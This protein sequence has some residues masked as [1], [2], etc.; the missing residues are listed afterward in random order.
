MAKDL[1]NMDPPITK[2]VLHPFAHGARLSCLYEKGN[3]HNGSGVI[4]PW[5]AMEEKKEDVKGF[6]YAF[7]YTPVIH[8]TDTLPYTRKLERKENPPGNVAF[9]MNH[10][11]DVYAK[12]PNEIRWTFDMSGIKVVEGQYV[13]TARQ[14]KKS[15]II[16]DQLDADTLNSTLENSILALEADK[17]I[18]APP[19]TADKIKVLTDA[20]NALKAQKTKL[21]AA[22][23]TVTNVTTRISDPANVSNNDAFALVA[24]K[25]NVSNIVKASNT[26]NSLITGKD[27][28]GKAVPTVGKTS[29]ATKDLVKN[30]EDS[31][32]K[33]LTD[34]DKEKDI[35]VINLKANKDVRGFF[36]SYIN[37]YDSKNA[38]DDTSGTGSVSASAV[39]NGKFNWGI[40][41]T[42]SHTFFKDAETEEGKNC[43]YIL[44]LSGSV[45]KVPPPPDIPKENENNKAKLEAANKTLIEKEKTFEEA[46]AKLV[47]A[48]ENKDPHLDVILNEQKKAKDDVDAAKLAVTNASSSAT[49]CPTTF[50]ASQTKVA[51]KETTYT[52]DN[53]TIVVADSGS[54]STGGA[55]NIQTTTRTDP[56]GKTYKTVRTVDLVTGV[57]TTTN[58][59]IPAGVG[60]AVP[61]DIPPMGESD[62]AK[63]SYDMKDISDQCMFVAQL[64]ARKHP[65]LKSISTPSTFIALTCDE[66]L[67][68]KFSTKAENNE[69]VPC[70]SEPLFFSVTCS[71]PFSG[72]NLSKIDRKYY[73][74]L[75]F[76]Y[77]VENPYK[78]IFG[79]TS[80]ENRT[81]LMQTSPSSTPINLAKWVLELNVY[82]ECPKDLMLLLFRGVHQWA[83]GDPI[84]LAKPIKF[85]NLVLPENLTAQA[86]ADKAKASAAASVV[87]NDAQSAAGKITGAALDAALPDPARSAADQAALDQAATVAGEA[88]ATAVDASATAADQAATDKAAAAANPVTVGTPYKYE[89][90]EEYY[91][92]RACWGYH[93]FRRTEDI[94]KFGHDGNVLCYPTLEDYEGLTK[95]KLNASLENSNRDHNSLFEDDNNYAYYKTNE[96]A[97]WTDASAQSAVN[98]I[99]DIYRKTDIH[100]KPYTLFTPHI[101]SH[102]TMTFL[103]SDSQD[104][105]SFPITLKAGTKATTLIN[106]TQ[107]HVLALPGMYPIK[108]TTICEEPGNDKT[109]IFKELIYFHTYDKYQADYPV[110]PAA[111]RK[112]ISPYMAGYFNYNKKAVNTLL[113][114]VRT[115]DGVNEFKGTSDL[116][117]NYVSLTKEVK[118]DT[119]L[120]VTGTIARNRYL[121]QV[122]QTHTRFSNDRLRMYKEYVWADHEGANF[123]DP[124]KDW[125]V[126]NCVKPK[127]L[128][129]TFNFVV[130]CHPKENGDWEE[131]WRISEL[132]TNAR[133]IHRRWLKQIPVGDAPLLT[134]GGGSVP[135]CWAADKRGIIMLKLNFNGTFRATVAMNRDQIKDKEWFQA[136]LDA[137]NLNVELEKRLYVGILDEV[138]H[139]NDKAAYTEARAF[140]EIFTSGM[141]FDVSDVVNANVPDNKKLPYLRCFALAINLLKKEKKVGIKPLDLEFNEIAGDPG[142]DLDLADCSF[143]PGGVTAMRRVKEGEIPLVNQFN[144]LDTTFYDFQCYQSYLS[145]IFRNSA[146]FKI[147][148]EIKEELRT[149]MINNPDS[150]VLDEWNKKIGKYGIANA[151]FTVADATATAAEGKANYDCFSAQEA[152]DETVAAWDKASK[153]GDYVSNPAADPAYQAALA[154]YN[155]AQEVCRV[156][157]INAVELRAACPPKYIYRKFWDDNVVPEDPADASTWPCLSHVDPC[158]FFEGTDIPPGNHV[159]DYTLRDIDPTDDPTRD[160]IPIRT[161]D[162]VA[163]LATYYKAVPPCS[164]IKVMYSSGPVNMHH[165]GGPMGAVVESEAAEF[166]RKGVPLTY[167]TYPLGYPF[168]GNGFAKTPYLTTLEQ[169][170]EDYYNEEEVVMPDVTLYPEPLIIGDTVQDNFTGVKWVTV[171]NTIFIPSSGNLR[172][173]VE[174]FGIDRSYDPII[175]VFEYDGSNLQ[176]L[177]IFTAN[178]AIEYL[179][180]ETISDG[181]IVVDGSGIYT[182]QTPKDDNSFIVATDWA[183]NSVR[184]HEVQHKS[185]TGEREYESWKVPHRDFAK[186]AAGW[187]TGL[188][189]TGVYDIWKA[190]VADP[191]WVKLEKDSKSP[192]YSRIAGSS[193]SGELFKTFSDPEQCTG[194][195]KDA[196]GKVID[197]VT[198]TLTQMKPSFIKPDDDLTEDSTNPNPIS[199]PSEDPDAVRIDEIG[200]E[201]FVWKRGRSI[202]CQ[203]GLL[204]KTKTDVNKCITITFSKGSQAGTGA[205]G[206]LKYIL[207]KEE[208]NK[209]HGSASCESP[210]VYM[211]S[212]LL[213]FTLNNEEHTKIIVCT[214]GSG[215]E[216][217]LTIVDIIDLLPYIDKKT[218]KGKIV[219]QTD[220]ADF[221]LLGIF[222]DIKKLDITS[223]KASVMLESDFY[224]YKLFNQNALRWRH[225]KITTTTTPAI[226]G[227]PA[228]GDKP[229]VIAV[230]ATTTTTE[231]N[232]ILVSP[233]DDD[234]DVIDKIRL[235]C[236]KLNNT[237]LKDIRPTVDDP[238]FW[239][240]PGTMKTP[241]PYIGT[242]R[243]YALAYGTPIYDAKGRLFVFYANTRNNISAMMS[244]DRG[245]TW[246]LYDG[247]IRLTEDETARG[248][249]TAY[250]DKTNI[251]DLFYLYKSQNSSAELLCVKHID[252][253]LFQVIDSFVP[254]YPVQKIE[255]F[256]EETDFGKS[257]DKTTGKVTYVYTEYGRAIRSAM[258]TIVE[259]NLGKDSGCGTSVGQIQ[260]GW[261]WSKIA[262]KI[263][264]SGWSF[265]ERS[266]S[267]K[268]AELPKEMTDQEKYLKDGGVARFKLGMAQDKYTRDIRFARYG[269]FRDWHGRLKLFIVWEGQNEKTSSSTQIEG[270]SRKV[271]KM[272][273]KL[274]YN[275]NNWVDFPKDII[276]H[277]IDVTSSNAQADAQ[278]TLDQLIA[279][280]AALIASVGP[281]PTQDDAAKISALL[282]DIDKAIV[283]ARAAVAAAN[284]GY[285]VSDFT[286]WYF[287]NAFLCLAKNKWGEVCA[288]IPR[289]RRGV[290]S[291][292][293]IE[294]ILC[295]PS[296]QGKTSL[297]SLDPVADKNLVTLCGTSS[298]RFGDLESISIAYNPLT[299]DTSLFFGYSKTISVRRLSNNLIDKCTAEWKTGEGVDNTI[300]EGIIDK[301][302]N[303]NSRSPNKPIYV[304]GKLT[305]ETNEQSDSDATKKKT[306]KDVL[307]ASKYLIYDDHGNKSTTTLA[308]PGT[309][310]PSM[311]GTAG[312]RSWLRV[313]AYYNRAGAIRLF[314]FNEDLD[315][316]EVTLGADLRVKNGG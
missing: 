40:R 309:P 24:A 46:N 246:Y 36:V 312:V 125:D 96:P 199:D 187:N 157:W 159:I 301:Q 167:V 91:L 161:P 56:S 170:Y 14:A 239:P 248:P 139:N 242:T 270:D 277:R 43:G 276:P 106:G 211:S 19:W 83:E 292:G 130:A 272:T 236:G 222:G 68:Y 99:D 241:T 27:S 195:E 288:C 3:G 233:R 45:S 213:E 39:S 257:V 141:L 89:T 117:S 33:L 123:G 22:N 224:K 273:I 48:Q 149:K 122:V 218:K 136:Y 289:D 295:E 198:D 31:I 10:Y 249:F 49:P 168:Y 261:G 214:L 66:I 250:N 95:E 209:I 165:L 81:I 259:G 171:S 2:D 58:T 267:S 235:V 169:L 85:D 178:Q 268:Y 215:T 121:R 15:K 234:A 143:V 186:N 82:L 194:K 238:S 37:E 314:L 42:L 112:G 92:K 221:G 84:S 153:S 293:Y 315:I 148:N 131:K 296:S 307:N 204:E 90:W 216:R 313:G 156:S 4:E 137:N 177:N 265:Y 220:V 173:F 67:K 9:C 154:K 78:S 175:K 88:Y 226:D 102:N 266:Y 302:F 271:S 240:F 26:L 201:K 228:V 118:K 217:I 134:D 103:F 133:W 8:H 110:T 142:K 254:Y 305:D 77:K 86:A 208:Y 146:V 72:L 135:L 162:W 210:W 230:P 251:I 166:K 126:Y 190:M 13:L 59:M 69:C 151:A 11:F 30:N 132:L 196:N 278:A 116:T 47:L 290:G 104:I 247:L 107:A 35:S 18:A 29:Q 25:G 205:G 98:N 197:S 180:F 97:N 5:G 79:K 111:P 311:Y 7:A 262:Y 260:G 32:N 93:F 212:I 310:S 164:P 114:T 185:N 274:C 60:A 193:T 284:T 75:T 109:N 188:T 256:K 62:Y 17:L 6:R 286:D 174:S 179:A 20:N 70:Y 44:V 55:D 294:A 316:M 87:A 275:N 73:Q 299:D 34:A 74:D 252:A 287:M 108:I 119:T 300:I 158:P 144:K 243:R 306:V 12:Q 138:L 181:G 21:A 140:S 297:G 41:D 291:S 189:K 129:E 94:L 280:R 152:Y 231:T 227:S 71:S 127:S 283:A 63:V 202:T 303:L 80:T 52:K 206:F 176:C 245:T 51:G 16:A 76:Q 28:Q 200:G 53:W 147:P 244:L 64:I 255:D 57:V 229:A 219:I 279:Q 65:F 105:Q 113:D 281:R 183:Y 182:A 184:C 203:D 253:S 207:T 285:K 124:G 128:V 308:V 237:I 192:K 163:P 61:W 223:A 225:K 304:D 50:D 160:Q 38:L 232:Q 282:A 150:A 101:T 258:S 155:T 298:L 269:A 263:L 120:Y 115:E 145:G 172:A 100:K 264:A 54:S 1:N 191:D 23:T